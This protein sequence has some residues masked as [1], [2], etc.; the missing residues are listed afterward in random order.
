MGEQDERERSVSFVG[1]TVAPSH[2]LETRDHFGGP[3]RIDV[4]ESETSLSVF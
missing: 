4:N 1:S 3:A 2:S